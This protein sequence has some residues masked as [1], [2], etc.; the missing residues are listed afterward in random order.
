MRN[1]SHFHFHENLGLGRALILLISVT[2]KLD[3]SLCW[4]S[5]GNVAHGSKA[6]SRAD[7]ANLVWLVTESGTEREECVQREI[8]SK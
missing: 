5:A 6:G 8:M 2:F 7:E 3:T 4:R 1:P